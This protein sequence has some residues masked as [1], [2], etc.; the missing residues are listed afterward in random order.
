L[1]SP[2]VLI[3]LFFV[4]SDIATLSKIGFEEIFEGDTSARA[5]FELYCDELDNQAIATQDAEMTE[6]ELKMHADVK[7][8]ALV[9][10]LKAQVESL[11]EE[12]KTLE[13]RCQEWQKLSSDASASAMN[14]MEI[15][16]KH[17]G[18]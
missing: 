12:N 2:A 8:L 6:H 14:W 16:Y 15:Y 10:R 7:M 18:L 5:E 11:R 3:I 13:K 17:K 1:T 4:M 9:D